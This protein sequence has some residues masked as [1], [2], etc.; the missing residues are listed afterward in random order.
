MEITH[1]IREYIIS[2]GENKYSVRHNVGKDFYLIQQ[3]VANKIYGDR[4][5]MVYIDATKDFL[6]KVKDVIN[7]SHNEKNNTQNVYEY[8]WSKEFPNEEL[9]YDDFYDWS[10]ENASRALELSLEYCDLNNRVNE[11]AIEGEK[12]FIKKLR[13]I[14]SGGF[15]NYDQARIKGIIDSIEELIEKNGRAKTEEEIREG[16]WGA[17]DDDYFTKYPEDKFWYKYPDEVIEEF[18]IAVE[19]LRIAYVYAQRIDW[20][21]SGD[22]SEE[23]FMERLKKD[24]TLIVYSK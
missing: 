6:D 20:L 13:N 8:I 18:K 12:R 23:S 24:L 7:K 10:R 2:D 11:G 9:N 5:S 14:M 4:N 19:F 16:A 21:L 22:D 15:F 17:L 3:I 1:E